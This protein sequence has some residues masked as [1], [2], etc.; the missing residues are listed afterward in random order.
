MGPRKDPGRNHKDRVAALSQ[1][2]RWRYTGVMRTLFGLTDSAGVVVRLHV[3]P[4]LLLLGCG[5]LVVA[6]VI[7]RRTA[8]RAAQRPS[9]VVDSSDIGRE[10]ALVILVFIMLAAIALISAGL[11][12]YS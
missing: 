9:H 10:A 12:D 11:F 8:Q 4:L 5:L 7:T 6:G 3:T 1:G 2:V